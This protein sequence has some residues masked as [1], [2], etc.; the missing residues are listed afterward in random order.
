MMVTWSCAALRCAALRCAAGLA[1][2]VAVNSNFTAS[3]F[4]ESFLLLTL[5]SKIPLLDDFV[6]AA[7]PKVNLKLQ[8]ALR[9]RA[10]AYG[11]RSGPLPRDRPLRVACLSAI[12]GQGCDGRRIEKLRHLLEQI[13]E[14]EEHRPGNPDAFAH[15]REENG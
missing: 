12:G 11:M 1:D 8:L 9:I 3:V 14:K 13:R 2:A 4:R 10:S 15:T 7:T 6:P 5:A